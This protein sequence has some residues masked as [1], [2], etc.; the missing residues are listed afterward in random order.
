MPVT[1]STHFLINEKNDF[2]EVSIDLDTNLKKFYWIRII[3]K[4]S[5]A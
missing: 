1:T 3:T 4:E 2:A 5:Q